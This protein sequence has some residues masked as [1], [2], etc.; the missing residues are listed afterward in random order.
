MMYR[1]LSVAMILPPRDLSQKRPVVLQ[2][3][4][5]WSNQMQEV[6]LGPPQ[7][8]FAQG[9]ATLWLYP[10]RY[11]DWLMAGVIAELAVELP[12]GFEVVSAQL[13]SAMPVE[14]A[15]SLEHIE[16]Y[17]NSELKFEW[18]GESWWDWKR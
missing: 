17:R 8:R 3:S 4:S 7:G 14:S 11:T 2:W 12:P 15:R 13:W 9:E 6:R 5:K 1:Y 10:G 18:T 16:H